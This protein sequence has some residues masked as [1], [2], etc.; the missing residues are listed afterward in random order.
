[1]FEKHGNTTLRDFSEIMYRQYGVRIAILV[2]YCDGEGE[3]AI[4][5]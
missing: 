4:M 5:L 1:M 2:G 3:P